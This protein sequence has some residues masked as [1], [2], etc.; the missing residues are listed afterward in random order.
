[1]PFQ[2]VGPA[3]GEAGT[4]EPEAAKADVGAGETGVGALGVYC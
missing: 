3:T 1:M 4:V 2:A